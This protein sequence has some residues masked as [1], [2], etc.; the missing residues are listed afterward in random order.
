MTNEYHFFVNNLQIIYTDNNDLFVKGSDGALS[1]I[2]ISFDRNYKYPVIFFMEKNQHLK[3]SEE[4]ALIILNHIKKANKK[5]M[6]DELT[7]FKDKLEQVT[8]DE[9]KKVLT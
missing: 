3:I 9:I 1:E 5:I 6:L 7:K 2:K 4:S 8:K